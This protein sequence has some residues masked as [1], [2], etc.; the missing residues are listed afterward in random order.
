MKFIPDVKISFLVPEIPFTLYPLTPQLPHAHRICLV[1]PESSS[2]GISQAS[3]LFSSETPPVL[4]APWLRAQETRLGFLSWSW[5]LRRAGWTPAG[6]V[7][8]GHLCLEQWQHKYFKRRTFVLWYEYQCF[9]FYNNWILAQEMWKASKTIWIPQRMT[10]GFLKQQ[11]WIQP[12]GD[13]ASLRLEP[14]VYILS[15][16]VNPLHRGGDIHWCQRSSFLLSE[17][18]LPRF[19]EIPLVA[20][21]N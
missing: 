18:R 20:K 21:K 14:G 16:Q 6:W 17:T 11:I 19:P 5:V 3:V 4:P 10:Y 9:R 13:R 1:W 12:K 15:N 7:N 8:W 2:Q